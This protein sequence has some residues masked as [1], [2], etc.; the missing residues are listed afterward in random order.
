MEFILEPLH[1]IVVSVV[2]VIALFVAFGKRPT[3]YESHLSNDLPCGNAVK[4]LLFL[5]IIP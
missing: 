2:K 5:K 1:I 3:F 4:L